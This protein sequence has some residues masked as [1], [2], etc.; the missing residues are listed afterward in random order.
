[1]RGTFTALLATV[2]LLIVPVQLSAKGKTVRITIKGGDV[3]AP[4][5]ITDPAMIAGFSVWTGPGTST[6][7]PQGLIVDWSRGMVE[8]PQGLQAYEVSI[9]TA[10]PNCAPYVMSYLVDP[11][12]NEGY[13]YLPGSSDPGYR[14]NVWLI[15]RGIEGNWFHAWSVWEKF[16]HP[17][18]ASASKTH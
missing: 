13:V 15:Y 12:T 10:R 16:A 3:A 4:I 14:G 2:P 9:L 11:S 7:E 5:E 1:M 17:L 8:P 6:N 18:I